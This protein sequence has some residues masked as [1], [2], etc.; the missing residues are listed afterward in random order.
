MEF[1]DVIST[2]LRMG[3]G[4]DFGDGGS[5]NM[6]FT[7]TNAFIVLTAKAHTGIAIYIHTSRTLN[8]MFK[9]DI[10]NTERTMFHVPWLS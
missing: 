10:P 2:E 6:V 8:Q 4:R 3:I 5:I 1:P 7:R 9:T